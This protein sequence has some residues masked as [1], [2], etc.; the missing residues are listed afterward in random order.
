MVSIT[1]RR[2]DDIRPYRDAYCQVA[3]CRSTMLHSKYCG[4]LQQYGVSLIDQTL[5]LTLEWAYHRAHTSR[6]TRV[7][8]DALT[9]TVI[10]MLQYQV[11]LC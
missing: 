7:A 11:E 4:P 9:A 5:P 1:M 8:A 2:T 6:H 10:L 3:L